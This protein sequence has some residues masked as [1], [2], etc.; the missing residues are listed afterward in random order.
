MKD[1]RK[2]IEELFALTKYLCIMAACAGAIFG[3]VLAKWVG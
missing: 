3:Y 2:S 1:A